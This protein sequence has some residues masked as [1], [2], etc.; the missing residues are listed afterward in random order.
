MPQIKPT[1]TQAHAATLIQ[2]A[3][4]LESLEEQVSRVETA[5]KCLCA[6]LGPHPRQPNSPKTLADSRRRARSL[7]G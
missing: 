5:L 2:I 6:N 3:V 4:S 7:V 1:E